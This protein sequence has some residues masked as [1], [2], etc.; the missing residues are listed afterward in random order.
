MT[1]GLYSHTKR[2]TSEAYR[3]FFEAMQFNSVPYLVKIASRFF[4]VPVLVTNEH[5]QLIS[6]YPEREIGTFVYDTLHRSRI[7]PRDVVIGYHQEFLNEESLYYEPFYANTGLVSDCPRI[8]GEIFSDGRIYGHFAVMMG[9]EPLY[10]TDLQC[11]KIFSEAVKVLMV[12]FKGNDHNSYSTYLLN[13]LDNDTPLELRAFAR[14]EISRVISGGYA[15]MVTRVGRQTSEQAFAAMTTGRIPEEYYDVI[16]AIYNDSLVSLFGSVKGRE[17]FSDSE[18]AFFEKAGKQLSKAGKSGLSS[19]FE[20]LLDMP[21]MYREARLARRSGSGQ[22][23]IFYEM[24]P[25]P[26]FLSVAEKED[27]SIFIHPAIERIGKYDEENGTHYSETLK[28]YAMNLYNKEQ[29]A[30]EL[31]IHRNTLLYRIN[32]IVELFGLPVEER[33]TALSVINSFQLMDAVTKKR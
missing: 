28:A 3:T 33:D 20:D 2:S 23:S 15:L 17:R 29:T 1:N 25:R 13:L 4:G 8:F 26:L 10:D 7:L 27:W 11:A 30:S 19:P 31:H 12:R 14:E 16:S 6:L 21:R 5:Y 9:P 18:R 32:R 24:M 22:V